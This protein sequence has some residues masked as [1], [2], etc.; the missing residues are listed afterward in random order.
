MYKIVFLVVTLLFSNVA[1]SI[2]LVGTDQDILSTDSGNLIIGPGGSVPIEPGD[3]LSLFHSVN[4]SGDLFLDYSLFSNNADLS[5]NSDTSLAASTVTIFSHSDTPTM[6]S[7]FST[8]VY[9]SSN[10]N[11]NAE[12][13]WVIF[14]QSPISGGYFEAAGNLYIGNYSSIA[15]VPIPPAFALFVSGLLVPLA[16]RVTARINQ[17]TRRSTGLVFVSRG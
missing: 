11:I 9:S 12:G 4:V 3:G 14:G 6:P 1:F 15:P 7:D 13:N 5:L 17:L 10:L 16:L 2:T 8:F